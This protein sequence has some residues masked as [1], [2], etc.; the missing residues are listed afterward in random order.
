[1]DIVLLRCD[2]ARFASE[3]DN[4]HGDSIFFAPL[5]SMHFRNFLAQHFVY[6]PVLESSYRSEF[7]DMRQ[8]EEEIFCHEYMCARRSNVE[9]DSFQLQ[10]IIGR[11]VNN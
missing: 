7:D 2:R 5:D 4:V 8:D 3:P 6:N 1:M 9:F 11:G 10:L